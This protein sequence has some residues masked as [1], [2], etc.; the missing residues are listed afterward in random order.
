[1]TDTTYGDYLR[2]DRILAAQEP[3]SDAHDEL[4]FIVIHQA[5]ELWMKLCLHELEGARRCLREDN[6]DPAFK[7]MARVSRVQ[8]QLIQS[9]EVL[10]TM[11]PADYTRVRPHL[12]SSS[13]FQSAQY[14]LIEYIMGNKN[15]KMTAVHEGREPDHARLTAAERE[16][17]LY[18]EALR[19]LARRGL[20]IPDDRLK[21]DFTQPYEASDEVEAAWLAI[22]RDPET[23]WDLYE[24]AEKLVDLQYH[25]QLWR[26]GHLKTVERVIGYKAGTGGTPGVPYLEQVVAKTF[27]PELLTVRTAL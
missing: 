16:P 7:M 26:F 11:T 25:F 13:G 23:Y 2:L 12:G 4:L 15:P 10:S 1:M 21:R 18:D 20:A 22:Y 14:R 8:H 5:S 19:V 17:S 6:L 3:R 24:L 27:F 9:W